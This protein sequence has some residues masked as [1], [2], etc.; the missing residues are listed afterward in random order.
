MSGLIPIEALA[1]LS[2]GAL[3]VAALG[4]IYLIA[5]AATEVFGM[6]SR[7]MIEAAKATG[8]AFTEALAAVQKAQEGQRTFFVNQISDLRKEFDDAMG[9]AR[10]RIRELEQEN[11]ALKEKNAA[12][13]IEVQLLKTQIEKDT[14]QKSKTRKAKRETKTVV[15]GGVRVTTRSA[16]L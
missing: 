2:T 16:G 8:D 13:E 11:E 10:E 5:K 1:Q 14:T 6:L 4:I 15:A 12:L 9:E 7:A 3:I